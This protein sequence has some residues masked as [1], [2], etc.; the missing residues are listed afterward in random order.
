MQVTIEKSTVCVS[1]VRF[2][3][4]LE[5]GDALPGCEF[6]HRYQAMP[7]LKKAELIEGIV[8]M[9]SPVRQIHA[10]P[11]NLIQL[12]LGYYATH[13]PTVRA[14]TNAT[15]LLDADNILQPDA[16][17]RLLPEAGGKCGVNEEGYLIG[18][19]ELVVEI[20]ASS[21]SIE[22]RDK[23]RVYRRCGVREYLV[24][25]TV[26]GELDWWRLKEGEFQKIEP[27]PDGIIESAIF[28]G[29]VLDIPALLA[30]DAIRVLARLQKSVGK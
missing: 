13:T 19:P 10:E 23:L 14:A 9:G 17:L 8:Y 21:A 25:R 27:S 1:E 16:L 20:A 29:L 6:L 26:Q 3:Q 18:A 5:N 15:V 7:R 24:W 30:R 22:V 11:D 12:V 4:P 28:P 2:E